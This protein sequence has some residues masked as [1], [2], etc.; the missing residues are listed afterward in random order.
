MSDVLQPIRV[1][2]LQFQALLHQRELHVCDAAAG[3]GGLVLVPLIPVLRVRISGRIRMR[4]SDPIM[5]RMGLWRPST[6]VMIAVGVVSGEQ[7][8]QEQDTE[9]QHRQWGVAGR[10]TDRWH[11]SQRHPRIASHCT[12][13]PDTDVAT[14]RSLEQRFAV[15]HE[16]WFRV[17]RRARFEPS[18]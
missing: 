2:G 15:N 4:T 13:W 9:H 16:S 12:D 18:T 6:V 8:D 7:L 5:D 3:T 11:L 14:K 1:G 17:R 10:A